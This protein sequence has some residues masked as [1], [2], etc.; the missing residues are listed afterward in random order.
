[1]QYRNFPVIINFSN[2]KNLSEIS[3]SISF[4]VLKLEF[5]FLFESTYPS[6]QTPISKFGMSSQFI[7]LVRN[8]KTTFFCENFFPKFLKFEAEIQNFCTGIYT[9]RYA[10]QNK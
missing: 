3:K 7:S 9:R 4:K 1:M 10:D 8:Y 5:D 6:L 2:V